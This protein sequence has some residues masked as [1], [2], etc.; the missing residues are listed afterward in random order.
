MA[1]ST[2]LRNARSE[3]YATWA[4]LIDSILPAPDES[5]LVPIAEVGRGSLSFIEGSLADMG[6]T[7]IISESRTINGEP[8]FRVLVPACDAATAHEAVTGL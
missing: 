6:I 8:R 2:L 1:S 4:R 3:L 5:R 7:A